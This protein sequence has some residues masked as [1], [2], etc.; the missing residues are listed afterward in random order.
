MMPTIRLAPAAVMS[1]ALVSLLCAA[2]AHAATTFVPNRFDDPATGGALCT[3]PAPANGCSLRGAVAAAQNGDTIRLAAGTYQLSLGELELTH[4]ITIVGAGATTTT[5]R[6][7][8]QARVIKTEAALAMSD[9]TITGGDVIGTAGAA[10][11]APKEKGQES[12]SIDGGGILAGGAL[13]LTGVVVTGNQ[14]LGG[15]GGAGGSGSGSA[16]GGEGGRGATVSGAGIAGGSPLTLT[17]VAIT[18]NVVQGGAGGAGGEGGT[19]SAGGNGGAAGQGLGAGLDLGGGTT[20]TATDTLIADN[21]ANP[22][23]GGA[24]GRGGSTSGAPG[25]GGQGE[26]ALAGGLFSN[27]TVELTNV[28]IADNTAGGSAGGTGGAARS[29]G[30]STAGAAGGIGFG[31]DGGGVALFNGAEGRFASVTIAANATTDGTG[32]VGGAGSLGGSTGAAGITFSTG[33]GD[34]YLTDA[35]LTLR[36]SIIASGQGDAGQQNCSFGFEGVLTSAGHNLDDSAQC[37]LKP[38]TGDLTKTPAGLATLAYNGG[39]TDTMALQAGSAAIRAGASPCLDAG[40]HTLTTDQRGL[41]RGTPCDI[42]AFEGQAPSVTTAPA[43]SGSP[44]PGLTVSCGG[45]VFG[46]DVPQTSAVQWLRDGTPITGAAGASY[47][48][49]STD[50]GHALSCQQTVTNAFGSVSATSAPVTAVVATSPGSFSPLPLLLPP[51]PVVSSLKLSPSRVRN[52]RKE[53]IS[54]TLTGRSATVK[55]TLRLKATGVKVGKHCLARS[56][57]HKRGRS[58]PR[59]VAVTGAPKA[60]AGKL[61]TTKVSW[62]PRHLLPG[63]YELTATPVG[64]TAVTVLFHVPR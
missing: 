1:S 6:Q 21:Q 12:G 2:S 25:T 62:T 64:G 36:D 34:V 3:P 20:V 55:F 18:D 28:T 47:T 23:D 37:I 58:C 7:T 49:A 40:S 27:G 19:T 30:T 45:G 38:T 43:V 11:V 9:L 44:A 59:L 46:G 41:P 39:S 5:I 53:T 60:L 48:V 42:G 61:G 33:G 22:G 63:T 31:G 14:V 52:K 24:G 8:G 10:G 32:G 56:R 26:P 50:V 16:G 35:T 57:K 13:S 51:R 4:D 15:D 54:L 29:T 17:D